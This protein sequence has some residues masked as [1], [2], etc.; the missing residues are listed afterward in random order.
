MLMHA[1]TLNFLW[2]YIVNTISTMV[3]SGLNIHFTYENIKYIYS[4]FEYWIHRVVIRILQLWQY[5]MHSLFIQ[6]SI[7]YDN[8]NWSNADNRA[9]E[10]PWYPVLINYKLDHISV[11]HDSTPLVALYY[12]LLY[13][14]SFKEDVHQH[15]QY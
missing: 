15:F 8:Y 11:T 14:L 3:Q 5:S 9:F 6:Y 10:D 12:F 1:W 13:S 7:S 4:V 2:Y